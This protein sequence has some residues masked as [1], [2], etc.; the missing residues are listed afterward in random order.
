[1]P[2]VH[3][4]NDAN[5]PQRVINWHI[6]GDGNVPRRVVAAWLGDATNVPRLFYTVGRGGFYLVDNI[7][8]RLVQ[9][10][11]R[12]S[13]LRVLS[14]PNES[15]IDAGANSERIYLMT[16]RAD[17]ARDNSIRF[18]VVGGGF[19]NFPFAGDAT[20]GS[21]AFIYS[22]DHDGADQPSE[23][24]S[25]G[26]R[27]YAAVAANDDRIFF[28]QQRGST[29]NPIRI[30]SVALD[31]S[32]YRVLST[33]SADT[34]I[35]LESMDATD[36]R[37]YVAAG[38]VDQNSTIHVFELDGSTPNPTENFEAGF[39]FIDV[40]VV[41]STLYGI[42]P[43]ERFLRAYNLDGTRLS[44]SDIELE[45]GGTVFYTGVTFIPDAAPPVHLYAI[46]DAVQQNLQGGS[47]SIG[48]VFV[49]NLDGTEV[50]NFNTSV[51]ASDNPRE[52]E[53]TWDPGGIAVTADRIYVALF[54]NEDN[55]PS[56]D[57]FIRAFDHEGTRIIADEI[58]LGDGTMVSRPSGLTV[59]GDKLYV[60]QPSV[61]PDVKV[62]NVDGTRL[63]DEDIDLSGDGRNFRGLALT[64]N[65]VY[66]LAGNDVEVWDRS[67]TRMSGEDIDLV[68]LDGQFTGL[69]LHNG[70]LYAVDDDSG[71]VQRWRVSDKT[72][73]TSFTLAASD[74][75]TDPITGFRDWEG[76]SIF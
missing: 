38:N 34:D 1:M 31:G 30:E 59:E 67:G 44:G 20:E 27:F 56:R 2:A 23:R 5:T 60:L 14:L 50:S 24:L 55:P 18:G 37:I 33:F 21:G 13:R 6:G 45:T 19:D 12:G 26:S 29:S 49:F 15:W 32:D 40:V 7:G 71:E 73:L 17:V 41:D 54:E 64:S 69:A 66:V 3:I 62:W 70:I 10:S 4:G 48:W 11:E 39:R 74:P 61:N 25:R 43:G 16:N 76:L 51:L 68:N 58:E 9:F 35:H 46:R 22:F 72:Q 65:R 75:P 52:T 8:K 57:Q 47:D 36:E 63:E 42:A 53:D 28:A